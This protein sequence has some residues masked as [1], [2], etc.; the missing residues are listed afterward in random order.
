M[1]AN[2]NLLRYANNARQGL[3]VINVN[4]Q[5]TATLS[6]PTLGL[7]EFATFGANLFPASRH[8]HHFLPLRA[9]FNFGFTRLYISIAL[10][11]SKCVLNQKVIEN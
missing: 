5:V 4:L 3:R 6:F 10:T 1:T 8:L 2:D 7:I 9:T 11:L